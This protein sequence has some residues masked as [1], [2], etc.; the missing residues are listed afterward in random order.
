MLA[1][2]ARSMQM[3]GTLRAPSTSNPHEVLSACRS[4]DRSAIALPGFANRLNIVGA[5]NV[6]LP[7]RKPC[8]RKSR[9]VTGR[10]CAAAC[11]IGSPWRS[12]RGVA[13]RMIM[14]WASGP[15]LALRS[16]HQRDRAAEQRGAGRL[17]YGLRARRRGL[18]RRET[19]DERVELAA[20]VTHDRIGRECRVHHPADQRVE[21]DRAACAA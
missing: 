13:L 2:P 20:D 12:C 3:N 10:L 14:A 1:P 18:T 19:R 11:R 8:A 5:A 9:R 21:H 7:A 6:A 15:V 17:D 4:G 16:L